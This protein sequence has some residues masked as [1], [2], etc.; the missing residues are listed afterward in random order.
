MAKTRVFRVI[1]GRMQFKC[2]N[3]NAKRMIGVAP[4]VR[5]RTVRCHKCG[6][7]T[8]CQLN[9]RIQPREQ[10]FGKVHL[11]SMDGTE[12]E[13]NLFNISLYGVGFEIPVQQR[14]RIS[15]GKV[16]QLRCAWNPTLVSKGTYVIKSVIG[17]RVGAERTQKSQWNL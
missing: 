12:M 4:H 6:E 8:S 17:Q 2:H 5:R 16:I 10:Q 13:V 14:T 1:Q 15:V 9:R 7:P 3:C 11:S